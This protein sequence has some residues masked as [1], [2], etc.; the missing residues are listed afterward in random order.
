VAIAQP[1]SSQPAP[2][3]QRVLRSGAGKTHPCALENPLLRLGASANIEHTNH[4]LKIHLMKLYGS[5]NREMMQ[6]STIERD[7]SDL[8]IKG[9]IFGTMPLTAKLRP[10]EAR[11]AFKLLGFRTIFFILTMFFR[12]SKR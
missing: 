9:K 4:Q 5:D 3:N 8:L 12:R 1:V 7:G 6:V 11:A 10:E 2:I